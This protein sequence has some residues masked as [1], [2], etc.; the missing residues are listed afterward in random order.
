M[1]LD[2]S[3]LGSMLFNRCRNELGKGVENKVEKFDDV[4]DYSSVKLKDEVLL[5]S[6]AQQQMKCRTDKCKKKTV[7]ET[8]H[9]SDNR[10]SGK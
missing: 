4:L 5:R 1:G 10:Y 2:N 8:G 7:E 6:K 3:V 9:K